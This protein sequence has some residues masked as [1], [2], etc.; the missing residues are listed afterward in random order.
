MFNIDKIV[1]ECPRAWEKCKKYCG[2]DTTKR[3]TVALESNYIVF[4]DSYSIIPLHFRELYDF[5]DSVGIKITISYNEAL[6]S[7]D[8]RIN[9]L[10]NSHRSFV[11]R[12]EAEYSAIVKAFEIYENQLEGE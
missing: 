1:K 5:F 4:R 3:C 8:W 10:Y 11:E 2:V 7:F 9:N 12:K 6:E